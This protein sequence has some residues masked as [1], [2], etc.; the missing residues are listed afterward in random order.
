[1]KPAN[2][3]TAKEF[4]AEMLVWAEAYGFNFIDTG[5]ACS[6]SNARTAGL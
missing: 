3:M 4:Q 6:A 1:M 2:E 5:M